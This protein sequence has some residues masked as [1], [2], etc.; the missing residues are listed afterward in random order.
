MCPPKNKII[1]WISLFPLVLVGRGGAGNDS[2][3]AIVGRMGG[4][5]NHKKMMMQ[6]VYGP[7]C[8]SCSQ[9]RYWLLAA[10]QKYLSNLPWSS[11]CSWSSICSAALL[12]VRVL[13]ITLKIVEQIF[14]ENFVYPLPY[15]IKLSTIIKHR[16][17]HILYH[18]FILL[19]RIFPLLVDPNGLGRSLAE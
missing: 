18:F 12:T 5:G 11:V 3:L 4:G 2:L 8:K 14:Y 17:V 15:F 6:Y 10:S 1:V 13:H 9:T 19:I 16:R 7:S